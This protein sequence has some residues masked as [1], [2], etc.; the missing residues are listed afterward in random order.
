MS[1]SL[2]V[3]VDA[4]GAIGKDG[5]LPWRLPADLRHFKRLTMGHH[6]IIGRRTWE[7]VGVILPGRTMVVVT[8]DRGYDPGVNGVVVVHSF[9][10]ALWTAR[11]D[12]EPF[13]AGGSSLYREALDVV[14]RM[15]FTR[16]HAEF[17]ADTF[18]PKFD[19]SAWVITE[20]EHHQG[21]EKNIW[22]YTFLAYE[23]VPRGK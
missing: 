5:A 21:D 15:Y 18:F 3:A 16:I 11:G 6:L 1:G 13:V 14:E 4:N 9:G 17:E 7:S 12:D 19:G 2:I 10:E 8:R 23:R 20:E 22:P